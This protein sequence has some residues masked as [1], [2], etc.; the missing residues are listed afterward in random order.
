MD[1]RVK[2]RSDG[3]RPVPTTAR[4]TAGMFLD[5]DGMIAQDGM[6]RGGLLLSLGKQIE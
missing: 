4:L 1:I 6:K 2:E 5:A 3:G